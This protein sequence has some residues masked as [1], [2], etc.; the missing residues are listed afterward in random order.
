MG[1]EILN[2]GSGR[3]TLSKTHRPETGVAA[4]WELIEILQLFKNVLISKITRTQ[5]RSKPDVNTETTLIYQKSSRVAM[6]VID[7][8][9]GTDPVDK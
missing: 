2:S 7:A 4:P 8:T 5:I 9:Q 1:R 6:F 3:K